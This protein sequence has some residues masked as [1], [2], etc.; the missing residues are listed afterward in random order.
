MG[1][2]RSMLSRVRRLEAA[3]VAPVSP[4]ARVYGSMDAFEAETKA[5]IEAGQLD[6]VDMPIVIAC[7]RRWD[8]AGVWGAWQRNRVWELGK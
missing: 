2:V 4:F 6:T 7:L 8:R 5:A 1:S 3:R